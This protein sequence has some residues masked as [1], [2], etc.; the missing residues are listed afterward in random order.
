MPEAAVKKKTQKPAAAKSEKPKGGIEAPKAAEAEA[1]PQPAKEHLKVVWARWCRENWQYLVLGAGVVLFCA[2]EV[3]QPERGMLKIMPDGASLIEGARGAALEAEQAARDARYDKVM[4][5]AQEA[6]DLLA[7]LERRHHK[8]V[9]AWEMPELRGRMRLTK[10]MAASDS[11]RLTVP[12]ADA[13][14]EREASAIDGVLADALAAAPRK[15]AS[16][17]RTAAAGVRLRLA[18]GRWAEAARYLGKVRAETM[19]GNGSAESPAAAHVELAQALVDAARLGVLPKGDLKALTA[20]N[21]DTVS[22]LARSR[23]AEEAGKALA[24]RFANGPGGETHREWT[25][26]ERNDLQQA[27]AACREAQHELLAARLMALIEYGRQS[28]RDE[29][30]NEGVD[31]DVDKAY[32][33]VRSAGAGGTLADRAV[34]SYAAFQLM[35]DGDDWL[36]SRLRETTEADRRAKQRARAKR[37][38][39]AERI[40]ALLSEQ[41]AS[42]HVFADAQE[43]DAAQLLCGQAH[44]AVYTYLDLGSEFDSGRRAAFGRARKTLEALAETKRYPFIAAAARIEL[45]RA[46]A[47]RQEWAAVDAQLS[48]VDPAHLLSRTQAEQM[49]RNFPNV[50]EAISLERLLSPGDETARR[51]AGLY[52]QLAVHYQ[53]VRELR[54]GVAVLE[55][56]AG[57]EGMA[58]A[59]ELLWRIAAW[60]EQLS[61][62]T[63]NAARRMEDSAPAT[64]LEIWVGGREDRRRAAETLW[65]LAQ[66][67]SAN[68]NL[69]ESALYKMAEI[70]SLYLD[71]PRRTVVACDEYL[72]RFDRGGK[73]VV[74]RF[75][76]AWAKMNLGLYAD[77]AED[78]LKIEE[79]NRE[80]Y[81]VESGFLRGECMRLGGKLEAADEVFER[82]LRDARV[83]PSSGVAL[84]SLARL[85]R[86][87]YRLAANRT[88]VRALRTGPTGGG[89]ETA[90]ASLVKASQTLA[91]AIE[92]VQLYMA[93]TWKKPPGKRQM[94][95]YSLPFFLDREYPLLLFDM[96][97][98][99]FIQ[100]D[101]A[102][103][104][105]LFQQAATAAENAMADGIEERS[106]RRL[107]AVEEFLWY[108]AADDEALRRVIR[109][110]TIHKAQALLRETVR[111]EKTDPEQWERVREAFL[112]AREQSAGQKEY[113]WLAYWMGRCSEQKAA[114]IEARREALRPGTAAV[115]AQRRAMEETL[116][117]SRQQAA[118]DMAIA[119]DAL[120]RLPA[121]EQSEMKE[122]TNIVE[123]E[124]ANLKKK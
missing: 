90:E 104:E 63:L 28:T 40:V 33:D 62:E 103:A 1:Q 77:A 54:K 66:G 22:L 122:W 117:D 34:K 61:D 32:E 48:Q 52:M 91:S 58:N 99:T 31:A 94:D 101:W 46:L 5:K 29:R 4:E 19:D 56:M 64:A 67:G 65:R 24:L 81:G 41:G 73:A 72:K 74:M 79:T 109:Y 55:R 53:K 2:I 26:A 9:D 80:L 70:Y 12:D 18:L 110:G 37:V 42:A 86:L 119:Q 7:L 14:L 13:L 15:S 36:K 16:R 107:P 21:D 95:A 123:R 92:R 88:E 89:D 10:A 30:E 38:A 108:G 75:R 96:A 84:R 93:Q 98:L 120:Q 85:G 49:S 57:V 124:L 8:N 3:L 59:G 44:L 50:A 23:R 121:G 112:D 27:A 25:S 60:H 68:D 105:R 39:R 47:Q 113:P 82:L 71:D 102:K 78:F 118:L 45:A 43:A 6:D 87:R 97:Q 20:K 51:E 11:C 100:R 115:D 35:D 116:R 111:M 83:E 106:A 76:R 114:I 17:A 69:L